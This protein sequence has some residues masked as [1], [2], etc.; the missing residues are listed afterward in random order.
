MVEVVD[1]AE[2]VSLLPSVLFTIVKKFYSVDPV[3]SHLARK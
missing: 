3:D 2:H 1:N